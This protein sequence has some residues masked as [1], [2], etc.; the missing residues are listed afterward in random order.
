MSAKI[1]EK[2]W[3]EDISQMSS[4][5]VESTSKG[6]SVMEALKL[7]FKRSIVSDYFVKASQ[8]VNEYMNSGQAPPVGC[9]YFTHHVIRKLHQTLIEKVW[10]IHHQK[11]NLLPQMFL[12]SKIGS[13]GTETVSKDLTIQR[14]KRRKHHQWMRGGINGMMSRKNMLNMPR[15]MKRKPVQRDG[16]GM[17]NGDFFFFFCVCH[18]FMGVWKKECCKACFAV[19]LFSGS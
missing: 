13:M 1:Q 12:N 11:P 7:I 19:I 3:G 2:N 15:A 6:W 10:K 9:H 17:M 5:V 4:K 14:Q 16:V 8:T 18:C